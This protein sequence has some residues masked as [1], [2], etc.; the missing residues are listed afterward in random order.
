MS[1]VWLRRIAQ[2]ARLMVGVG[3]YQ[4]YVAHMRQHHPELPALSEREYFRRCQN[5]R[6][7]AEAGSIKRCPC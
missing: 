7:G 2:T 5:S 3:D 1:K 4:E 6:Y